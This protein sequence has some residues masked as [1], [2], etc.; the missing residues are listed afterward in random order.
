M[1]STETKPAPQI[2]LVMTA[3]FLAFL[4]QMT[5]NPIIAP[6]SREVGLAEWQVGVTI[7]TAAVMVVLTAQPWGRSSQS[8]GRKRVLVLAFAL[9]GATTGA[10]ALVAGLGMAGA[11]TGTALF[12]LFVALRGI[13]FG[14]A[15]AA[16]QPTAQAYIADITDDEATRV[17]GMAGIGAAQGIAQVAGA[18]AGGLLAALGLLA[19]VIA[20]PIMLLLGLLLVLL[21][22]RPEDRT[23]LIE[24]P[25]RVRATDGRVWPFL[26]AGFGMFTALGFIQIVTGF[27]VQDRLGLDTRTAG[28]LTGAALLAAGVGMILAQTIVV[29]KSRWGPAALLRAG[30]ATA[31]LGFLLLI[32]DLGPV[33]LFGAIALIGLGLGTAMPGYT[34]GPTLL[35]SREEQGGLAGVIAANMGLTFVVAPTA[36]TLLYGVWEPLP[37]IVAAA[38]MAAVTAFVLAHPRFRR[39]PAADGAPAV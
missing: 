25:V 39:I 30:G 27:L 2:R 22:L 31:L 3:A 21:R 34:A 17:K 36:S 20:V 13:G 28:V 33:S 4:A 29:P 35:V 9:G 38:I 18:V 10:F 8:L 7:S 15:I 14:V 16:V 37:V 23:S 32:P 11:L 1:T 24:K 12:L 26:L 5:L 19:P 6:L